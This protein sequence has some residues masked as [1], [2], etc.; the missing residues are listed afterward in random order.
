MTKIYPPYSSIYLMM[1]NFSH[2]LAKLS[3][4]CKEGQFH[5]FQKDFFR[6]IELLSAPIREIKSAPPDCKIVID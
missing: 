4:T 6:S 1:E 2:N 5:I 3:E